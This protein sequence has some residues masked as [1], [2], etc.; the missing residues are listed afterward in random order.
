MSLPED[1]TNLHRH[2]A[3]NAQDAIALA[4]ERAQAFDAQAALD[5]QTNEALLLTKAQARTRDED[6]E[7]SSAT[8]GP[9]STSGPIVDCEWLCI[10]T[11]R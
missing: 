7:G 11:L 4:R 5:R 8:P 1:Q 6:G 3:K 2:A 10:C 9:A